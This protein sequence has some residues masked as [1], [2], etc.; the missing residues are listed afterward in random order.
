[1]TLALLG[2][3][4]VIA[5]GVV[6]FIRM[7]PLV[8]VG[9]FL[10]VVAFVPIWIDVPAVLLQ[11]SAASA[12]AGVV[13]LALLLRSPGFRWTLPDLFASFLLISTLGPFVFGLVPFSAVLSVLV[14]WCGAFVLGR[15]TLLVVEPE[16][17]YAL[18]AVIF[19][20]V[21]LL[22]VVEF[23]TGWHGLSSWGPANGARATWGS[24][25]DR[26]GL[27]RAEGAFG[28]SIALGSTLAMTAVLTL[29][30]RLPKLVR[31]GLIA[32]MVAGIGVTLSRGALLCL[33]I[34]IALALLFVPERRVRELRVPIVAMTVL[35][36]IVYAPVVLGV[37]SQAGTEASG[38]AAY[39]G[40]LISL[41]RVI[42]VVGRSAAIQVTPEG[43]TYIGGFKSIDNQ[44]LIFGLN[45]G[46]L[47]L[48]VVTVLLCVAGVALVSGRGSTPT[49]AIAA[50]TPALVTVALVT[51]YAVFFWFVFGLAV[52][53]EQLRTQRRTR[54]TEV[55]RA[56]RSTADTVT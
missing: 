11:P 17:L 22:A 40:D 48:I 37:F 19:G 25:Q 20:I 45:F 10:L 56:S 3:M 53:A 24:I 4:G 14:I 31:L 50:Q 30:A 51:Q 16:L 8:G 29:Q 5:S 44:M 47:I 39:R 55:G 36:A 23:I 15:F 2:V 46:W 28:H 18:I 32:L 1:M 26:A 12:T 13:A 38:S 7:R 43:N 54:L 34:G 33:G 9:V 49:A 52:G 42:E 41:L 27:S 21:G 6:A 35:G